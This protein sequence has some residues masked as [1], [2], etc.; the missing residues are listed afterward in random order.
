MVTKV[1]GLELKIMRL[2]AGL[3]QYDV[4]ARLGIPPNRLSE[5]ESGRR[6]P[7]PELLE[8]LLQ[9][10]NQSKSGEVESEG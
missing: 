7:S 5:I 3:R 8:Q 9:I 1:K 6:E 2:R 10:V 4:A